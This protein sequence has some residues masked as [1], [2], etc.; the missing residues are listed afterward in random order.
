MIHP[1]DASI[2]TNFALLE[3]PR[4]KE[5]RLLDI[6]DITI[7]EVLCGAESWTDIEKY[8]RTKVKRLHSFVRYGH[9]CVCPP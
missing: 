3:D 8:E 9:S 2:L 7:Y 1:H 5:Y 6:I 4:G